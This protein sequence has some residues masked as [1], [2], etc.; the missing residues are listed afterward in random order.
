MPQVIYSSKPFRSIEKIGNKPGYIYVDVRTYR[1]SEEIP[2]GTTGRPRARP[3]S[4]WLKFVVDGKLS[5]RHPY[6]TEEE[7]EFPLGAFA[8]LPLE[9]PV[10]F[11]FHFKFD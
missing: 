6:G 10:E 8:G 5:M 9:T 7:I 1:K 2:L 3:I 4:H 11:V